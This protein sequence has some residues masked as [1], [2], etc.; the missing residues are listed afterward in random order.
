MILRS[1]PRLNDGLNM[2]KNDFYLQVISD[3]SGDVMFLILLNG[4]WPK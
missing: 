2:L 3:I 4:E 1:I